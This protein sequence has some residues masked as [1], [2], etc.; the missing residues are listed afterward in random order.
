MWGSGCGE[1]DARLR[2]RHEHD[3]RRRGRGHT[4]WITSL[5]GQP[6]AQ[7]FETQTDGSHLVPF[8]LHSAMAKLA[9]KGRCLARHARVCRA[10][11]HRE[12]ALEIRGLDRRGPRPSTRRHRHTKPLESPEHSECER[13]HGR[14]PRLIAGEP[15]GETHESRKNAVQ[16]LHSV[17]R[18]WPDFGSDLRSPDALV[19]RKTHTLEN[20]E[21]Q[22]PRAR[23]CR[24][25]R[26]RCPPHPRVN[27]SSGAA[28]GAERPG[29]QSGRD[30]LQNS[31]DERVALDALRLLCAPRERL[32][33]FVASCAHQ[34]RRCG[35]GRQR[36]RQRRRSG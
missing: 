20:G 29:G 35:Q 28:P 6:N 16:P 34:L 21:S 22:R 15:V 18:A 3:E 1:G 19:D 5:K 4:G 11:K 24:R 14:E 31:P 33:G 9:T 32:L 25:F 2:S 13:T 8:G 36:T 30:G 7:P 10:R 12:V 27:V 23:R 26:D 17:R